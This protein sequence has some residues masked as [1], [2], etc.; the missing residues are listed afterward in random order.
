MGNARFT[1]IGVA[2]FAL[3]GLIAGFAFSRASTSSNA[4]GNRSDAGKTQEL[5]VTIKEWAVPTKGAHPHDPAVRQALAKCGDQ[6][7]AMFGEYI[8]LYVKP[9][10]NGKFVRYPSTGVSLAEYLETNNLPDRK[11][12]V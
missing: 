11:S 12:V 2:S 8:T 9:T 7:Q 3:A 4:S 6:Y 10:G 1:E 5:K